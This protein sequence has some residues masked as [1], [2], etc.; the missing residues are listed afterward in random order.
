MKNNFLQG[1]TARI[2]TLL[3]AALTLTLLPATTAFAASVYNIVQSDAQV[4][5]PIDIEIEYTVDT[6]Q[7]TWAD[8]DSSIY[9]LPALLED[10]EDLTFTVEYDD[11]VDNNGVGETDILEG[12]DDGDYSIAD[13]ILT[14]TW[15]ETAW[16]TDNGSTI[17]IIIEDAVFQY[18]GLA[19]ILFAGVTAAADTNPFGADS[20]L[21]AVGALSATNIE[22]ES[23]VVETRSPHT[24]SFTTHV[25]IANLGKIVVTYPAGWSLTEVAGTTATNLSGLNGTWT[26]TVVGQVLTLTQTGGTASAAGIKSLKINGIYTPSTAGSGGAYGIAT[27]TGG[28]T[29]LERD[30]AVTADTLISGSSRVDITLGSV[31]EVLLAKDSSGHVAITWKDPSDSS[32][33]IAILRGK[34]G[35]PVNGIPYA[36]VDKGIQKFTDTDV[37]EGDTIKYILRAV[38]N[39]SNAGPLT[40]TFTF[41]LT[42]GSAQAVVEEEETEVPEETETPEEETAEPTT[43]TPNFTDIAGHWAEAIIRAMAGRG[44]VQG[45]SDGTFK[46]NDNLNRA[47][48][49][50]LLYRVLYG[51]TAPTVPAVAPFSDVAVDQ[52]YAGFVAKLKELEIADGNP[53]GTYRSSASINRAEFT[54]LAL[55]TYYYNG[56]VEQKAAVDALKSGPVTQKFADVSATAW[57]APV[58]T[59]VY[60][61]GVIEGMECEAGTCFNPGSPITRAEA[62]A[63]LARMFPE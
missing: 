35:A 37:K 12:G 29:A 57:Y 59:A 63:I 19:T 43:E 56:T 41:A 62:T 18:S 31:T 17:R 10:W 34:N 52:W 1:L 46:P 16:E 36:R 26:A 40:E 2:S 9:S 13:E 8:G 45:N 61:L 15:D 25:P 6:A 23:L 58:V 55:E 60:G 42:A 11:D 48:A 14:V 51:D 24:I 38:D 54:K 27:F 5:V 30:L 44:I 50:A 39:N 33:A 28:D 7:Q 20:V 53:D 22:S 21:V 47:E 4:G 32:S 3:V 49:A